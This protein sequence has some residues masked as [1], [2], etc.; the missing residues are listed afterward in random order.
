MAPPHGYR[1]PSVSDS[2]WS[3]P[4]EY[5]RIGVLESSVRLKQRGWYG[6]VVTHSLVQLSDV[7]GSGVPCWRKRAAGVALNRG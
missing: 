6:S 4:G 7:T 2:I 5:G 1:Q 3:S